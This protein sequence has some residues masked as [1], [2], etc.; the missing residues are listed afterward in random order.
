MILVKFMLLVWIDFNV[1][2]LVSYLT[3]MLNSFANPN[4]E[5]YG[6]WILVSKCDV[7]YY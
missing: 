7:I 1:C 2:I 5:S 6:F 3:Q 4:R